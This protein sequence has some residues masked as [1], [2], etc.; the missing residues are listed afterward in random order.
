MNE[1]AENGNY[2]VLNVPY[3]EAYIP[4]EIFGTA[5]K[6]NPTA[7]EYGDGIR[8]VGLFNIRFYDSD[9]QDRDSVKLRTLNYPNTI[10][11]HPSEIEDLTLQ[12]TPELEPSVYRVLKF[13][14][15]DIIMNTKSQKN[16]KNCEEFMNLLIRG[17]LPVGL[18]YQ[19]LYFGWIKNF[20]INNVDPGVPSITLQ[21]IISENCRSKDD[22][23]KQF[24]KVVNDEGVSM[25]DYRVQNMVDI[26]SNSSVLNALMF[27]RF[28][29][30]LTS[31]LLMSK[32]GISQNT[33]PLEKVLTM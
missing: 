1:F 6:G 32:E 21:T 8:A 25:T 18:N 7:Y 33:T 3:A 13:Y 9:E 27:E 4:K 15:G 12:L 20:E 5:E 10:T 28:G 2:V 31:S 26:C 17:K 14:K 29:E 19:D 22:P 24:R 23:M 16:S 11:M 30:M